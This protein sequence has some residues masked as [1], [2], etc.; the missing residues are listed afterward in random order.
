[1]EKV[2]AVL[3]CLFC[4]IMAMA[5]TKKDIPNLIIKIMVFGLALAN[6][7][8]TLQIFGYVVKQ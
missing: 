2:L 5:W 7:V 6:V 3:N 8:Y 1:M 4:I